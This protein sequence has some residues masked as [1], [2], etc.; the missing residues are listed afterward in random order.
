VSTQTEALAVVSQTPQPGFTRDQIDLIKTQIC[1]GASDAELKL[2][3]AQATRTGLDPFARQIYAI[4]RWDSRERREVMAV[5][6][7]IDGLRL[8]AERTGHYEGQVGPLWCGPDG[9]W[10]DVWLAKEPPAAAKV[11]VWR[12]NFREPLWAVARLDSYLQTNKEGK[13]TPLWARMPELMVAKCAESLALRKA[14]PQETSGLY[15][16]EEMGQADAP[17]TVAPEPSTEKKP[18]GKF[19]IVQEFGKMKKLIGEEHYRRILF[20]IGGKRK[21]NEF[22]PEE[23]EIARATWKAMKK[24]ADQMEVDSAAQ[25]KAAME[26]D[27]IP[28]FTEWPNNFDG[29]IIRVAGIVFKYNDERGNYVAVNE[30]EAA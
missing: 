28:T 11:G 16:T 5:Q 18:T 6:V 17:A 8:I 4:K 2:F 19:D 9:Q 1:R 22:K 26:A 23:V 29:P 21:S 3:M 20:D 30:G 24:V 25:E 12:R 13:P 15:T 10:T 27:A 7:S 14:F